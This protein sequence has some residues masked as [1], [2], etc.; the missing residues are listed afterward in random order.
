MELAQGTLTVDAEDVL[1]GYTALTR[2]KL[3]QGA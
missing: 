2:L 3:A 1:Q